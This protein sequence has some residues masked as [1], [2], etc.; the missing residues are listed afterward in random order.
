VTQIKEE[1]KRFFAEIQLEIPGSPAF[2]KAMADRRF[3][4][5][6]Q[7]VGGQRAGSQRTE[8]RIGNGGG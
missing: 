6:K 4:V 8:V 5:G 1:I 7:Q 2:A 3:T